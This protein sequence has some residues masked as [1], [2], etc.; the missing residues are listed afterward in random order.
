MISCTGFSFPTIGRKFCAP[1]VCLC[2]NYSVFEYSLQL[3]D[4]V[5]VIHE[6]KSVL[7]ERLLQYDC[8]L[9]LPNSAFKMGTLMGKGERRGGGGGGGEWND[10]G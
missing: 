2:Y 10:L 8:I 4:M 3:L 9:P 6:I 5:D 7:R 1:K